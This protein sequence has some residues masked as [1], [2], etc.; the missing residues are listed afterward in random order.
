[1][2]WE[3]LSEEHRMLRDLVAKFVERELMPL[4]P[5]VLAREAGGGKIALTPEEEGAAPAPSAKELGLWG[6]D[7]PEEFGGADL[8]VPP[9]MAVEEEMGRTI[10]PFIF[11]PDSPNLHM[12]LAV[13]DERQRERYLE[14]YAAARRAPPSPSP[15]PAPAATRPG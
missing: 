4:E 1:M 8:P 7:V 3:E 11:P 2:A 15:S 10:T 9:L 6:L 13:A 5:A 14:P 12:M